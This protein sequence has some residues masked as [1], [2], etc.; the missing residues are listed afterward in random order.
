MIS[1]YVRKI[2]TGAV[3]IAISIAVLLVVEKSAFMYTPGWFVASKLFRPGPELSIAL[4]GY[5]ALGVDFI[6]C[7][8]VVG[9]LYVL[10]F[11]SAP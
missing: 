2:V 8:A 5:T 9:V 11:R 6:S 10:F 3:C 4:Y 7:L 1:S